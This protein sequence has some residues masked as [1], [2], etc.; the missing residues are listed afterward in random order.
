MF[1]SLNIAQKS[2][3]CFSAKLWHKIMFLREACRADIAIEKIIVYVD[4]IGDLDETLS[5]EASLS[6]VLSHPASVIR[7]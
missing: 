5:A 7:S 3:H 1:S 4:G 2:K 6:Q